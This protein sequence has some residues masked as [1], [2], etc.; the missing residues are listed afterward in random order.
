MLSEKSEIVKHLDQ[1]PSLDS[2]YSS[3]ARATLRRGSFVVH[4]SAADN[5]T[6]LLP[7]V[8]VVRHQEESGQPLDLLPSLHCP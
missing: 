5:G 8:A 6:V 3:S 2:L 4:A 1:P 7:V